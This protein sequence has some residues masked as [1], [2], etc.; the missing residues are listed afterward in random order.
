MA[1]SSNW[2]HWFMKN[3]PH[4]PHFPHL[5]M[6]GENSHRRIGSHVWKPLPHRP[7]YSC[8]YTERAQWVFSSTA[9]ITGNHVVLRQGAFQLCFH[10]NTGAQKTA[11][12]GQHSNDEKDCRTH[13]HTHDKMKSNP[14]MYDL[15]PCNNLDKQWALPLAQVPN[16]LSQTP[17]WC[18]AW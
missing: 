17:T 2:I 7:W 18:N 4:C 12:A 10:P 13:P 16:S 8:T 5:T 6:P 1:R 3:S 11:V 9:L 14:N 15:C